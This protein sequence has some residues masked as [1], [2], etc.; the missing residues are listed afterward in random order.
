[1]IFQDLPLDIKNLIED[2]LTINPNDRPSAS[3]LLQRDIFNA[4]KKE[5]PKEQ[6]LIKKL[7]DIGLIELYHWYQLAGG[8]VYTELKK[9]GLIRSS[10]PIL[11]LPK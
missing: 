8:D 1:M 2:C 6:V 9:Q 7:K 3:E 11:S 5:E 4:F 10:P